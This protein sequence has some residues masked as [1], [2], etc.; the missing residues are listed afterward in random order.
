MKYLIKLLLLVFVVNGT[1]GQ[2]VVNP[3]LQNHF[4]EECGTELDAGYLEYMNRT[5]HLR[6]QVNLN[7]FRTPTIPLAIHVLI[8]DEGVIEASGF[9]SC[10]RSSVYICT[11]DTDDTPVC[12]Q[13]AIEAGITE[14]I[15]QVNNL[16]LDV[17]LEFELCM[18]INYVA[19]S[20]YVYEIYPC[21]NKTP[22]LTPGVNY[23][24]TEE[25]FVAQSERVE[26]ALNIFFTPELGPCGT[27]SWPH[28][29]DLYDKD[30]IIMQNE[31]ATNGST[32]AHEIGHFFNLLHTYHGSF[33]GDID[34][35]VDGTNCGQPLVGDELCDTPPNPHHREVYDVNGN[36][37]DSQF[38]Y[39]DYWT[40][41]N[42]QIERG[43]IL[44]PEIYDT[45]SMTCGYFFEDNP[46][47]MDC[48]PYGI[49]VD[50]SYMAYDVSELV[51][52]NIMGPGPKGCREYFSPQ[53]IERMLVSLV[54]DRPE[55]LAGGCDPNCEPDIF[56][57]NTHIHNEPDVDVHYVSD[58]ISSRA[59]V[60][61]TGFPNAIT[62]Y[63][64]GKKVFLNPPFEAEYEST[65]L[66]FIDGCDPPESLKT[67][68]INSNEILSN[69]N[70]FPNP[71]KGSTEL[72]FYLTKDSNLTISIFDLLGNQI[73]I[74]EENKSYKSGQHKLQFN[75]GQLPSGIY[76]CTIEAGDQF[77]TQKMVLT[78]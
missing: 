42:G 39:Y 29:K 16:Y 6:D 76:Y 17:G 57:S 63:N 18:P 60:S 33:E 14:S 53:Q 71:F 34:E 65:F 48:Y 26:G 45:C 31:C 51:I 78:K 12:D 69:L 75:G 25:F 19:D 68:G 23:D 28:W 10:E 32:L 54:V 11:G 20:E 3:V 56:F 5:Q 70:V 22:N 47:S 24:S 40:N 13:E 21:F 50:G 43:N 59:T 66:A 27:S 9:S 15:N 8:E 1:S 58:Y 38:F 62:V 55:L 73:N 30:W 74:L 35:I 61:A 64:A 77:E 52:Q 4:E 41:Q 7:V 72:E 49:A 2:L 36:V 44:Y 37:I 67:M 46:D